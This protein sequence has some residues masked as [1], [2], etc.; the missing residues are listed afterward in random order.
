MISAFTRARGMRTGAQSHQPHL[1]QQ[2][3]HPLGI[4]WVP[5]APQEAGHLSYPIKWRL[6]VLLIHQAHQPQ[7]LRAF[8]HR[9][10]VITTPAQPQQL[11]LPTYTQP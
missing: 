2:P 8:A 10:V 5:R 7:I 1:A 3:A 6:E 9:L 11:T 4:D